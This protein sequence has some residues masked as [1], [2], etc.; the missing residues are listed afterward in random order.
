MVWIQGNLDEAL[1]LAKNEKK[2]ILKVDV[3]NIKNKHIGDKVSPIL[4]L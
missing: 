3:R 1:I 2:D 4:D